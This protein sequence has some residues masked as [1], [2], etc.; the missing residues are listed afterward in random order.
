MLQKTPPSTP[1]EGAQ[2]TD[3]YRG[4]DR[5]KIHRSLS[6]VKSAIELLRKTSGQEKNP[7]IFV[8]GWET[9]SFPLPPVMADLFQADII[10]ATPCRESFET[11]SEPHAH[12]RVT[13]LESVMPDFNGVAQESGPFDIVSSINDFQFSENKEKHRKALTGLAGLTRDKGFIV[14]H[15]PPAP[16]QK[17]TKRNDPAKFR[18]EIDSFNKIQSSVRLEA[19][20]I[21]VSASPPNPNCKKNN[22]LIKAVLQ[23]SKPASP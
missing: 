17:G 10:A 22:W 2:Q 23:V 18:E 21:T 8:S 19:K 20:N 4:H 13:Y 11:A 5:L 9:E 14:V 7:R 1:P 15:Y 6:A 3:L 16:I 12:P